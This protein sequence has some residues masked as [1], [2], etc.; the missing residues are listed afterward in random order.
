MPSGDRHDRKLPFWAG[1]CEIAAAS[2]E[3]IAAACLF[4][5]LLAQSPSMTETL[6]FAIRPKSA[7]FPVFSFSVL[8]ASMLKV[9]YTDAGLCLDYCPEPLDL[10]LSDR[11]CMYAHAQQSIAVQPTTAS[12]PLP[13]ALVRCQGLERFKPL[14][15]SLCDR[16]W[17]EITLSGLWVTE[18]ADQDAGIFMTELSPRLEQRLFRLWHLSQTP[19][20]AGLMRVC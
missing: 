1:W 10:L 2:V 15:L 12:I 6:L 19:Q 11:I 5:T 18:G 7:F 8:C 20:N 14:K 3:A 9:T 16:D 4:V 17:M 13:T